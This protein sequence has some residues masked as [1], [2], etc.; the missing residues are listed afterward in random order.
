[1]SCFH[2]C[3]VRARAALEAAGIVAQLLIFAELWGCKDDHS[4]IYLFRRSLVLDVKTSRL[5]NA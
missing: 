3:F 2:H 1:M 4:I 5:E